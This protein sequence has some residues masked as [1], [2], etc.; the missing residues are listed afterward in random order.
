MV[1]INLP[2]DGGQIKGSI[3]YLSPFVELT[4]DLPTSPGLTG[5]R[6]LCVVAR[7]DKAGEIFQLTELRFLDYKGEL[8]VN[9]GERKLELRLDYPT[10]EKNRR[11]LYQV[12]RWSRPGSF[13]RCKHQNRNYG[14]TQCL[15]C[16]EMFYR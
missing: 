7:G 8:P 9:S 11:D 10:G 15:F 14:Q 4:V 13:E 2:F 1:V 3:P 12:Y 6:N 16:C 5:T